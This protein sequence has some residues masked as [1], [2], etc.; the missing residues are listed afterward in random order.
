MGLKKSKGVHYSAS[1]VEEESGNDEI[2]ALKIKNK[3]VNSNVLQ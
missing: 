2:I 3:N 1:R